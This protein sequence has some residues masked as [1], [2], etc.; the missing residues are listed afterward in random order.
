MQRKSSFRNLQELKFS[1][2]IIII[3]IIIIIT[4]HSFHILNTPAFKWARG[5]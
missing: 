5:V 2:I 4:K 1:R 3:I